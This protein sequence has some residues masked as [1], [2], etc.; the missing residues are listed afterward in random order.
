MIYVCECVCGCVWV[1]GVCGV[2]GKVTKM[3]TGC[4]STYFQRS[5]CCLFSLFRHKQFSFS[6]SNYAKSTVYYC[7]LTF[8][9]CAQSLEVW[10]MFGSGALQRK[11]PSSVKSEK[12]L[13]QR[14]SFCPHVTSKSFTDL[15]TSSF[16][17]KTFTRQF[18]GLMTVIKHMIS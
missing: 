17:R 8:C 14:D 1:C 10:G 16:C 12:L 15:L 18:P 3:E 7:G 4:F 13:L 6:P 9:K 11:Q 2:C 5:C